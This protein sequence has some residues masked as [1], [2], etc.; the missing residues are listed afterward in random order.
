LIVERFSIAP[1]CR[2]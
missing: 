2:C 1:S